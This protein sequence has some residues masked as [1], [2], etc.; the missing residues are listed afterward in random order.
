M[1]KESRS[2]HLETNKQLKVVHHQDY[3]D[4]V[5][6]KTYAEHEFDDGV[7]VCDIIEK[8][9]QIKKR[10][11][12]VESDKYE[13]MRDLATYEANHIKYYTQRFDMH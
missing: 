1:Q 11:G 7:K 3:I 13:F 6:P 8:V 9:K 2:R 4:I 10:I 12:Q 5:T